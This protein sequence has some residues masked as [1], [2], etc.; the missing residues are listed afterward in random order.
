MS[1]LLSYVGLAALN[2]LN[3]TFPQYESRLWDVTSGK[4][5]GD[6]QYTPKDFWSS[7][8]LPEHHSDW[9]PERM[10]EIVGLTTSFCDLMN[11]GP[12]DDKF[13]EEIR[14]GL[15][16]IADGAGTRDET[17]SSPVVV[18]M[19]FGDFD[20]RTPMN[21]TKTMNQ[22]TDGILSNKTNVDLWVGAWRSGL[23]WNHAKLIAVDGQFLHTGGHNMWTSDYLMEAPVHD[24]SLELQGEVAYGGHY[25]ANEQ[26]KYLQENDGAVYADSI[27][28]FIPDTWN[29]YIPSNLPTLPLPPLAN[30]FVA[31]FPH[32]VEKTYPPTYDNAKAKVD[33]GEVVPIISMGKLGTP[34]DA[35]PSEEAFVA[36]FD[37]AI[38][39]IKLSIQD[40]G[41]RK[42]CRDESVPLPGFAWP[43]NY[44]SAFGRALGRGV[45]VEIVYSN[46]GAIDLGGYSNGWTCNEVAAQII[47]T[48]PLQYPEI[49]NNKT[50]LMD[51][52]TNHLRIGYLRGQDGN[53][54][55]NGNEIPLH[56]KHFIIDDIAAYIGSENIYSFDMAEWGVVIDDEFETKKMMKQIWDPMYKYSYTGDDCD[57]GYV[58][59]NMLDIPEPTAEDNFETILKCNGIFPDDVAEEGTVLLEMISN[60]FSKRD[61]VSSLT[62]P[63]SAMLTMP[64]SVSDDV[65]SLTSPSSAMQTMSPLSSPPPSR[66]RPRPQVKATISYSLQW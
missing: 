34:L 8:A 60:A 5:I 18:R 12:P 35:E 1:N 30:A 11:L 14:K 53:Q 63:P 41:P 50:V 33:I 55:P 20:P 44:L 61:D 32:G 6:V 52:V 27:I 42:V 22:L 47:K 19:M 24:L 10:G 25:Y 56:T 54:Y 64:P 51:T 57:L 49:Y 40:V 29:V 13:L 46:L 9:F 7:S 48:I 65:P 66:L 21:V 26:W 16:T 38:S 45:D 3:T 28:E 2:E 17:T 31:D 4:I 59:E 62:S 23:S 36:M 37:S 58:V 43:Q 15:K 39:S